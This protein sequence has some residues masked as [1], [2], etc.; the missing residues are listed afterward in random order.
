MIIVGAIAAFLSGLLAWEATSIQWFYPIFILAG[1]ANVSIW[2]I[3]MA[4]TVDFGSESER[5][6][7]IGLSQTLTAPAA[8]LAPILGGWIADSAGFVPTFIVSAAL[9]LVMIGILTFLVKDPRKVS[10]IQSRF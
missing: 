7:Y 10:G 4:M 9:S 3:G 1:L 8:I 5:P 2:T 6:I